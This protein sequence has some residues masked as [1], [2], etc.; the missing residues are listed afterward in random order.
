MNS[1][2]GHDL[3]TA[4]PS[5]HTLAS[6]VQAVGGGSIADGGVLGGTIGAHVFAKNF[7]TE[8]SASDGIYSPLFVTLLFSSTKKHLAEMI[9]LP[10]P[11]WMNATY[12][13]LAS[14]CVLMDL[15]ANVSL[16]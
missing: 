15:G 3:P 7:S 2:F 6:I 4:L 11:S 16:G 13:P 9:G 14:C 5:G 1:Q 10:D 12:Q 8:S